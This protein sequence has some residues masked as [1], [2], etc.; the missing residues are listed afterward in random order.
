MRSIGN[1]MSQYRKYEI[2]PAVVRP[3]DAGRWFGSVAKLGQ[4]AVS[5]LCRIR[6][7]SNS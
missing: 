6:V 1:W 7:S 5:I 3:A 2:M 4:M